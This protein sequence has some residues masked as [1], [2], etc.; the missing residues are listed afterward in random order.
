MI[1]IF[2]GDGFDYN[3]ND[4]S[5]N[6]KSNNCHTL[7]KKECTH[8]L[9]YKKP[10]IDE[11]PYIA[12]IANTSIIETSETNLI[13]QG[14]MVVLLVSLKVPVQI[15][16]KSKIMSK[17][18]HDHSPQKVSQSSVIELSIFD[19]NLIHCTRKTSRLSSIS[20]MKHLS[21]Q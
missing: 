18:S 11:V 1:A 20:I 16:K 9:K 6:V 13:N 5:E 21:D 4:N 10:F 8:F 19:H 3:I 17:I 2:F 14:K 15:A 12:K 7:K